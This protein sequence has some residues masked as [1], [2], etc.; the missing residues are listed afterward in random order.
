MANFSPLY[1]LYSS[2]SNNVIQVRH[3]ERECTVQKY[4]PSYV[5]GTHDHW[6]LLDFKRAYLSNTWV[7]PVRGELSAAI[8]FDLDPLQ[9]HLHNRCGFCMKYS[10]TRWNC[11]HLPITVIKKRFKSYLV[12]STFFIIFWKGMFRS[13][14]IL[15]RL[16]C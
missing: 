11:A 3:K 13:V 12:E 1:V 9:C 8:R 10:Y 7:T 2:L 5:T 6:W 16:W 15:Y 4:R 14:W